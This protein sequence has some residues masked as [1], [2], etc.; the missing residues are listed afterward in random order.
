MHIKHLI[1]TAFKVNKYSTFC[2]GIRQTWVISTNRDAF[3]DT[4]VSES[5]DHSETIKPS[6]SSLSKEGYSLA[7]H[8]ETDS[9]IFS[10]VGKS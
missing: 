5:S 10:K 8:Y 7:K 1:Q 9:P 2:T 4:P 3:M 6:G